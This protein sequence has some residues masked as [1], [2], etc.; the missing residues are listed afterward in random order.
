MDE[1]ES[2][3]DLVQRMELNLLL[4]SIRSDEKLLTQIIHP[5]FVEFGAS[6]RQWYKNDLIEALVKSQVPNVVT[7]L[8]L[9]A[10]R[11]DAST[12]LVTYRTSEPNREVLRSSVWLLVSG[13]WVIRFHQGTPT[14][15]LHESK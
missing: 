4:P 2:D 10:V 3:L 5:E 15:S 14:A 12:I 6:G 7:V 11:V 8:D 13:E 9:L 1:G